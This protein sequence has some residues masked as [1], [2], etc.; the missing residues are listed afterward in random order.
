MVQPVGKKHETRPVPPRPACG[1][2]EGSHPY[3][4]LG[5]SFRRTIEFVENNEDIS[6]RVG[7]SVISEV[8]F[9]SCWRLA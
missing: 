2:A 1:D 7:T 5:P 9:K 8:S 4:Q 3:D 6:R